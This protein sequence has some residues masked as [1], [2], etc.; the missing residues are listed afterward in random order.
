MQPINTVGAVV[1]QGGIVESTSE[2]CAITGQRIDGAAVTSPVPYVPGLYL[3]I[4]ASA[5]RQ[6]TPDHHAHAISQVTTW[7]AEQQPAAPDQSDLPEDEP[8]AIDLEESEG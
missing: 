8:G 6:M 4:A 7:Y 5:Y 3:R 2:Y 1:K